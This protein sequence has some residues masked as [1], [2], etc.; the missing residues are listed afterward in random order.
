MP[1]TRSELLFL[2]GGAI[3][4]VVIA[5]NFDKIKEA[6]S[7]LREKFT[8]LLETAGEAFGDAYAAA[9][10]RVGERVEAMQD[11]MAAAGHAGHAQEAVATAAAH[12][13]QPQEANGQTS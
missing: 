8:P 5:K 12:A 1:V 13:A 10:R 4:G 2:C 6:V 11:A 7:P 3:A 9:A